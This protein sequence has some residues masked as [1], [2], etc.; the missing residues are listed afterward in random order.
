[1]FFLY[2]FFL[3]SWKK[4]PIIQRVKKIKGFQVFILFLI[5]HKSSRI[6]HDPPERIFYHEYS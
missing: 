4:G 3:F 5:V 2:L 6:V 1:M